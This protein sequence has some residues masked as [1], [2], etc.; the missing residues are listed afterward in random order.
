[1]DLPAIA[2]QRPLTSTPPQQEKKAEAPV[3]TYPYALKRDP[4]VPLVGGV[5]FARAPE[6][7]SSSSVE[8]G[9]V[10]NLQLRG[11]LNL[12]LSN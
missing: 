9:D 4:F 11:I 1:M 12:R 3:Y 2:P 5:S 7:D 6:S 10:G 8:K